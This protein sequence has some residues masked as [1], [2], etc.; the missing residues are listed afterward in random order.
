MP[1]EINEPTVNTVSFQYL[2]IKNR[3][4]RKKI[5][6]EIVEFNSITS[7]INWLSQASTACFNQKNQCT[8]FSQAHMEHS[9]RET[10]FLAIKHT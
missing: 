4:N 2:S 5:N 3:S 6:K 1:E 7:S 10:T 8:H 9:P